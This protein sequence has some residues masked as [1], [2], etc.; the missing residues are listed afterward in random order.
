MRRAD[1][2]ATVWVLAGLALLLG[3]V[4]ARPYAGGFNDGSRLATVESLIERSTLVIDDSVFVRPPP[5][6]LDRGL[7]P[8]TAD[9][10]HLARTGTLDRVWINGHFYSDKPMVPAILVAGAY[11]VLMPFGLPSPG[12]RPDVFTWVVTVLT[13]GLGY[14]AAV[15][16]LW[17]LGQRTGLGAGWRLVWLA[18]FALATVLPAYSRQVNSGMPQVAALAGV[19]LCLSTAARTPGRTP[20][21]AL[22]GVGLLAGFGYTLDAGSGPPLVAAVLAA[23]VFRFRRVTPVVV[24]L[25]AALPWIAFHHAVNYAVGGVWVPVNMVPEYLE[26][27]GSPFDRSNMTGLARH[28][29]GWVAHYAL[30]MLI[31][32]EGFLL[33]NPPLLLAVVAGWLALLRPGPD[34][35]EMAVLAGWCVAVW[36]AYA[37]LSDNLGGWCLT[38]R[39]F[40]PFIVPGFWLLARLLAEWPTFRADFVVLVCG[41][42]IL[43]WR[44][45]P[46]GPWQPC[47]PAELWAVVRPTFWAW[48]AVRVLAILW[49]WAKRRG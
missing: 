34:R 4:G 20:W 13:N 26:W 36:A 12:E 6:L 33:H 29:P 38:V 11:R 42:L 27:P 17:V 21:T 41:G 30:D 16:C 39:W 18:G 44:T 23:V 49:W 14:A 1:H 22:A 10:P 35:I 31:G 5:E 8:Y 37:V 43:T 47:P 48:G 25:L 15:G 2:P 3:A 7:N 40:V 46:L 24:V 9:Y 45:W 19:A 28:D 32:P